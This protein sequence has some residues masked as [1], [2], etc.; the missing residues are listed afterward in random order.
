MMKRIMAAIDQSAPA[1]RAAELATDIAIKFE[2]ELVLLTVARPVD[3][4]QQK[5]AGK[6]PAPRPHQ[7]PHLGK[8][9]L[10]LWFRTGGAEIR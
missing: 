6:Q 3:D 9:L 7:L 2:A 8:H 4:H 1:L 10:K 5:A